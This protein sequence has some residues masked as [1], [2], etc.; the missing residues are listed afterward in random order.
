MLIGNTTVYLK[1]VLTV[2]NTNLDFTKIL[3]K[4]FKVLQW[5]SLRLW[6][7]KSYIE[8][9]QESEKCR[10]VKLL[11]RLSQKKYFKTFCAQS[12]QRPFTCLSQMWDCARIV[13][14]GF[15][16]LF[17]TVKL[18]RQYLHFYSFIGAIYPQKYSITLT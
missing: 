2:S 18:A 8:V 12:L 3:V 10:R 4:G 1:M 9:T 16:W 5:S 13:M 11:A 6:K 14:A 7:T 15:V 17:W